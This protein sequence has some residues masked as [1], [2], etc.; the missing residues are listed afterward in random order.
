MVNA[1]Q[2]LRICGI[3]NDGI[4][5]LNA[6]IDI[7]TEKFKTALARLDPEYYIKNPQTIESNQGA[8]VEASAALSYE[9]CCDLVDYLTASLAR[10]MT[11]MAHGYSWCSSVLGAAKMK[12]LLN[13]LENDYAIVTGP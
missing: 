5:L 10:A 1:L 13:K 6:K 2:A 12:V 8:V 3:D 9:S 11:Q 7:P 4:R